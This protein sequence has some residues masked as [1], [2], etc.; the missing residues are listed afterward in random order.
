MNPIFMYAIAAA[1]AA[2]TLYGVVRFLGRRSDAG[3]EEPAAMRPPAAHLAVLSRTKVGMGRSLVVVQYENRRLLLGVT[4][5]AWAALAD[6][7][8][9]PLENEE[10]V[11]IIEAE[12]SR[13]MQADRFRRGRRAS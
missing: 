1:A 4:N 8:A 5:G 10:P 6:L 11:S 7:G 12:L 2:S 13:V 3:G 9:A